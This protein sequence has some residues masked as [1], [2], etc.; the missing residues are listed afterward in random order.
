MWSSSVAIR[1]S[2]FA[3]S[4]G[5]GAYWPGEDVELWAKLA[6]DHPIAATRKVTALYTV[7]TGGLMDQRSGIRFGAGEEPEFLVLEAALADPRYAAMHADI[8]SY[9][10]RLLA[11]RVH[12]ALFDADPAKA[13]AFLA[14]MAGTEKKGLTHYRLMSRLPA[15]LVKA[16]V[17]AFRR[18]KRRVVRGRS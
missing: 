3:A 1:R 9:R 11:S 12:Q 17:S 5:Y 7:E 16:G 15:P 10:A 8:R 6:L 14:L 18:L 2:A 13:R 4:G